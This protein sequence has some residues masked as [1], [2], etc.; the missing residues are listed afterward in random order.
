[1]SRKSEAPECCGGAT[2]L[3]GG[4][5]IYPHRPDLYHKRFY[6]CEQCGAYCGRHP[7]TTRPLGTP[8]GRE[9]REARQRAHAAFDPLWKSGK[10][11]RA[12]AYKWLAKKLGV[13]AVHI[14][15]SGLGTCN[16]IVQLYTERRSAA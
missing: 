3:V 12:N 2:S 11:K 16:R 15:E 1:M 13:A 4:K 7:R 6:L 10:M 5:R 8:A 9:L 14:G